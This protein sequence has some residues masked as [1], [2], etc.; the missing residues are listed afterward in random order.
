MK[1]QIRIEDVRIE[2]KQLFAFISCHFSF[3]FDF[4]K[5]KILNETVV[6]KQ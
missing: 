1:I 4:F 3:K 5:M 6:L 2:R